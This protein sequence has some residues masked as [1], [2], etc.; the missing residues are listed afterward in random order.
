MDEMT[1]T[2]MCILVFVILQCKKIN[3][4]NDVLSARIS[5]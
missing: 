3:K 4:L 2:T 1:G 5:S